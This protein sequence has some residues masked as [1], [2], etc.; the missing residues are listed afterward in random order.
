MKISHTDLQESS[1]WLLCT[2]QL[3]VVL[4]QGTLVTENFFLITD[5]FMKK[6]F[7]IIL[8]NKKNVK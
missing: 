8:I 1:T 6:K 4:S 3:F 2:E 5:H 7:Y